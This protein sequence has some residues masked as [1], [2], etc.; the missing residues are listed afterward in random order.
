MNPL[1]DVLLVEENEG[2]LVELVDDVARDELG[3]R[4]GRD[5]DEIVA[6]DM[7][8]E[9][10]RSAERVDR[11][12]HDVAQEEDRLVP[13]LVSVVVVVRLEIVDIEVEKREGL[14]ALD[15]ALELLLDRAVSRKPRERIRLFLL[16]AP[17]ENVP[18]AEQKLLVRVRLD[19]VVVRAV[20]QA[21]Y[22]VREL[23]LRREHDDRN[24]RRLEILADAAARLEAVDLRHHEVEEDEIG[25]FAPNELERDL[26]VLGEDHPVAVLLELELENASDVILVVHDENLVA[27]LAAGT[28]PCG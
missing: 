8:D 27:L 4:R 3:A 16:E 18:D 20:L 28:I 21:L 17:V 15:A 1:A 25:R 5:D 14:L 12:R 13:L 2:A 11:F 9:I 6:A 7:A 22:L 26:A 24:L 23:A 19:E 10:V